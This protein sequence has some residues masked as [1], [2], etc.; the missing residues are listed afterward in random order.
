MSIPWHPRWEAPFEKGEAWQ[1]IKDSQ[2]GSNPGGKFIGPDGKEYYAKFYADPEQAKAEFLG[3]TLFQK[4]GLGAPQTGMEMLPWQG[5]HR[6][7][8][9]TEWM[10]DTVPIRKFVGRSL[11]ELQQE[12]IA[13]HYLG[14]ALNGNWDVVGM[15]FDNLVRSGRTWKCIDQGGS[16]MFRARGGA[17]SYGPVVEELESLLSPGRKAAQVFGPILGKTIK[18]EPEKYIEWLKG[19]T[20][21]KI[22]NAVASAG[23]RPELANTIIRRR[24][25]IIDHLRQFATSGGTG[26][27]P[28]FFKSKAHEELFQG[29][30]KEYEGLSAEEIRQKFK[31]QCPTMRKVLDAWRGTT[32]SLSPTGLKYKAELMEQKPLKTFAKDSFTKEQLENA[33]RAIPDEEYIRVRA[34]TQAYY[35]GNGIKKVT[36]YRGTD[37]QKSGPA[38]RRK[39]EELRRKYP[40]QWKDMTVEMRETSLVGWSDKQSIA[41]SFGDGVGGITVGLEVDAKEIFLPHQLWP[42]NSYL[43][44]REFLVFGYPGRQILLKHVMI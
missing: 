39:V 38:Y 19:L 42:K 33:A 2:L 7:A 4:L 18:K 44:E 13:K 20:D 1:H 17:K 22:R 24:S 3:N 43:N 36:L 8:L 9:V 32:Q 35:R 41:K 40:E 14:A 31:A 37:G 30:L 11:P 29:F 16:F 34:M 10:E 27:G 12:Q 15:E 26:P 25:Y 6:L 28:G 21:K 23:F 5:G